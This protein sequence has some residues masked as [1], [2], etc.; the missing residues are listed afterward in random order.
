MLTR[1]YSSSNSSPRSSI[2]S[3]LAIAPLHPSALS[4]P[5][6]HLALLIS[7]NLLWS[8]LT[9]QNQVPL[10]PILQT[11]NRHLSLCLIGIR[12]H[13]PILAIWIIDPG[14]MT[15]NTSTGH[16][17]TPFRQYPVRQSKFAT[18]KTTASSSKFLTIAFFQPHTIPRC[19]RIIS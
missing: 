14:P 19:F 10:I 16:Q 8:L 11:Y 12:F 17:S 2:A 4:V 3:L 13:S 18:S 5:N 9:P 15:E 6:A 7:L 1:L